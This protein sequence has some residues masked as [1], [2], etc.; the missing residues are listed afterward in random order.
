MEHIDKH[1]YQ[2]Q[3]VGAANKLAAGQPPAKEMPAG[4]L[5]TREIWQATRPPLPKRPAVDDDENAAATV[6]K[7]AA[8]AAQAAASVKAM[9][10]KHTGMLVKADPVRLTP[11]MTQ[12]FVSWPTP[13]IIAIGASTGGTDALAAVLEP[14]VPPLPPIVVVQHIPPMFSR[15]FAERLDA[16][17]QLTVQEGVDGMRLESSH[18][19]IA[20]GAKHMSLTQATGQLRLHVQPGPRVN[21]VCPAVDVLFDSVAELV[22]RT[23]L[24]ILLT[25]MGRDGADGLLAMRRAGA[26]TLGQDPASCVVYGMPK[27]AYDSGA[28][29]QQLNLQ[30]MATAIQTIAGR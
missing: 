7:A 28:V 19:Y 21:S 22:G 13:S 20:P 1:N 8:F 12:Q 25:G 18:V 4:T 15:L 29:E 23:A 11:A 2:Q 14:L 26:H 9:M 16:E 27:A 10:A 24:G 30:D 3:A 6:A 5:V 17:C